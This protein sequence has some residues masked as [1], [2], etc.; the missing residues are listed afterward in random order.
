METSSIQALPFIVSCNYRININFPYWVFL[1]KKKKSR[2]NTWFILY[3]IGLVG[4]E[5][6]SI[7]K[8]SADLQSVFLQL[9]T[10]GEIACWEGYV[11]LQALKG[12]KALFFL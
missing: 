11:G 12:F 3:L 5:S 9:H 7:L 2:R 4:M 8:I 10:H 6:N 1:A